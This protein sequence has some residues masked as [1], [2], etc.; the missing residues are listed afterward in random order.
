MAVALLRK[1]ILLSVLSGILLIASFPKFGVGVCA[2]IA[3]LPLL[4][5]LPEKGFSRGFARGLT[6]G[7]LFY[8]G[9]LYWITF[10]VVEYGYFPVYLGVTAMLAVAAY[11]A[12]YWG[13]FAGLV[14][15]TAAK[16]IPRIVSAPLL[17][18]CLEYA[19]SHLLTGFPWENLAYSQYLT[20][21]SSKLPM[22]RALMASHSSSC[23]PTPPVADLI[24]PGR[25][26]A[27]AERHAGRGGRG[28]LLGIYCMVS[29]RLTR[30]AAD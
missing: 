28:S 19:K 10:A 8:I 20:S 12:L 15:V 11:L 4:L 9:L 17:F 5:A 22:L 16:G 30:Y 13:L 24:R 29:Y 2:W 21:L 7:F 3:L 25:R 14:S 6:T 1:P 27:P 26:E 23:L 18:T